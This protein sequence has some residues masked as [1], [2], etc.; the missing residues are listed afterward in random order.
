MKT[1][2]IQN[3]LQQIRTA[4]EFLRRELTARKV[5]KK[6][7]IRCV[8]AAE[9]IL[10]TLVEH[11]TE[12]ISLSV[13][14]FLGSAEI[15][16][17]AKGSEFSASELE[18]KLFFNQ[19]DSENE[20]ANAVIHNLISKL[21][22]KNLI[23]R[24][25]H[26]TNKV[27]LKTKESQFAQLF[28]VLTALVE[29]IAIGYILHR[30]FPEA[31][32][33]F[34]SE[35]VFKPISTL[36]M[37]ALKMIVAPLVFFSIA[38]SIADFS[39]IKALGRLALKVVSF[40]IITS[41]IAIGIGYLVYRL[42]PIGNPELA[43]GVTH[44]SSSIVQKSSDANVSLKSAIMSIV[45]SD[46]ITPFKESN[47]LQIIFM[48]VVAGLTASS[49][50]K[51]IPKI[52]TALVI[53]ND[54]CSK[55][56]SVLV[57]I[58]PLV[59]FC[60]MAN[61]MIS[62]DLSHLLN[63][64]SWIPA[65]Y[66]GYFCMLIVDLFLLFVVGGLN[67]FKFLQKFYPAMITAFSLASSNA[68]LPASI[69]QADEMGI[70]KKIYSFSLPLGAT[71]NMNGSC[72]MLMITAF[73]MAKNFGI[74]VTGSMIVSLFVSILILSIGAPGVPGATLICCALLMPQIGVPAESVSLIMGMY[75]IASMM[76]V[77]MN[78]TGDAV[79][80]A[81]I[82]RHEGLLDLQKYNNT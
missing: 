9:E 59:V 52:K 48:A 5:P 79:A 6:E 42:V 24:Y 15:S 12:S 77:C 46:I 41:I 66:A 14:G 61:M 18:E 67:P 54:V 31:V 3:D 11:S 47:M 17:S 21:Y 81:V 56:T 62:L 72:I 4:T 38:S 53:F 1:I 80:T 57:G 69:K 73:F 10:S 74:T 32:S 55:I 60:S 13:A 63:V 75:P 50:S 64:A 26:G 7:R 34:A 8:L 44:A 28:L 51:K 40:Y 71:I 70:S 36:F 2:Q 25:E 37:N 35:N 58:I 82:A 65:N 16:F 19:L 43:A 78:V 68:T 22:G 45:P 39:D 30:F 20:E 23:V 76:N 29:G 27:T 33:T 49:L